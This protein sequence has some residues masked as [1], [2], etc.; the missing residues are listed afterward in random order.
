[1]TPALKLRAE[2]RDAASLA[3]YW[4]GRRA[5][6][7]DERARFDRLAAHHDARAVLLD[8]CAVS[9]EHVG[10][11]PL[12]VESAEADAILGAYLAPDRAERLRAQLQVRAAWERTEREAPELMRRWLREGRP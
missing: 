7:D 2:A 1:M 12:D 6:D 8:R 10:V 11:A 9:A 3:F 5:E 4:R